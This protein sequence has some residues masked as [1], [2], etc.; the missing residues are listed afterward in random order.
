[1]SNDNHKI[2]RITL[3][4]DDSTTPVVYERVK[5]FWYENGGKVLVIA[6]FVGDGGS[7]DY[8]HWPVERFAWFRDE[9]V[10]STGRISAGPDLPRTAMIEFE[11]PNVPGGTMVEMKETPQAM[12]QAE[13]F[14]VDDQCAEYFVVSEIRVGK[15]SPID[16]MRP[17]SASLFKNGKSMNFPICQP[18]QNLVV[19]ATNLDDKNSHRFKGILIGRTEE[20]GKHI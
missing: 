4:R 5:H 13:E 1:M 14:F 17:I 6:Y 2:R 11:A 8:V 10:E 12:F 18:G 15:T 7:H 20:K 16:F 19:T 3:Y 9:K